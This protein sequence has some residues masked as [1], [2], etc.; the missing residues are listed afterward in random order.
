MSNRKIASS[1][2]V[3]LPP[4]LKDWLADYAEE[5]SRNMTGQ[6]IEL[7]KAERERAA[8]KEQG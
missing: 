4:H 2:L 3:R 1:L 6:L 8:A 5:N 7:I